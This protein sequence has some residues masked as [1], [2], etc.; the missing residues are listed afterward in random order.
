MSEKKQGKAFYQVGLHNVRI[1]SFRYDFSPKQGLPYFELN[2]DVIQFVNA[3]KNTCEEHAKVYPRNMQLFFSKGAFDIS[4]SNLNALLKHAGIREPFDDFDKLNPESASA[5][6]LVGKVVPMWC[7]HN[8]ETGYEIWK[9]STEP[10]GRKKEPGKNHADAAMQLNNMFQS[11]LQ[12]S[13]V[14]NQGET[15]G[16]TQ[17]DTSLVEDSITNAV[18]DCPF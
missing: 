16:N 4:V 18:D 17:P 5:Y 1:T 6:K 9:P 2:F 10:K 14:V 15:Q 13:V 12:N 7:S 3:T 8:K 11:R